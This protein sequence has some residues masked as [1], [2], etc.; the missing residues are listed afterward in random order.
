MRTYNRFRRRSYGVG[1]F[2]YQIN[3]AKKMVPSLDGSLDVMDV[4]MRDAATGPEVEHSLA[5][6][7]MYDCHIA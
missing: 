6:L 2:G 7:V 5:A 1:G 4:W 3:D